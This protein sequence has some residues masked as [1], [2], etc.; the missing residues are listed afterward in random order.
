MRPV[1][2]GVKFKDGIAI[3]EHTKENRNVA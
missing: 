2:E 1:I 3:N